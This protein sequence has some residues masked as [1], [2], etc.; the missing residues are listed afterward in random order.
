M[1]TQV[2]ATGKLERP[3]QE[4]CEV[5]QAATPGPSL[6]LLMELYEVHLRPVPWD[7]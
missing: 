3:G 2:N 4:H 5:S 1:K 7:L 6:A